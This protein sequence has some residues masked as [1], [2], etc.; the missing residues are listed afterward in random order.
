MIAPLHVN[1]EHFYPIYS[2]EDI[3]VIKI[4]KNIRIISYETLFNRAHR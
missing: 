3:C 1:E 2:F 4:N